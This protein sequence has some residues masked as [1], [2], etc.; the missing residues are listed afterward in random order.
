M[1]LF[2]TQV[3]SDVFQPNGYVGQTFGDL[4]ERYGNQISLFKKLAVLLGLVATGIWGFGD[5][6]PIGL[7]V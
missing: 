7:E 4:L 1:A 5:L 3:M 2:A 6:M